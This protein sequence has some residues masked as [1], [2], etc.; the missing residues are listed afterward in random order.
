MALMESN[1]R[2]LLRTSIWSALF[3]ASPVFAAFSLNTGGPDWDYTSKDL[4]STTSQACKDAYG[5]TIDC[6]ETLMAEVATMRSDFHPGPSDFDRVC[7]STC[8]Q[9]LQTWV[10]NVNAACSEPGDQA[11]IALSD[12]TVGLISPV[13]AVGMI[14]QYHYKEICAKDTWVSH[15]LY[16]ICST[17][18]P[19]WQ[20]CPI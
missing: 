15:L 18:C 11:T 3:Q 13:S 9:S 8:W 2:T 17:R 10:K 14:Y 1:M 7:T 6:N 20:H 5:S 16:F 12:N 19:R 4:S